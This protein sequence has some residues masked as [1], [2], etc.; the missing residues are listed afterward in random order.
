M[1]LGTLRTAYEA[2]RIEEENQVWPDEQLRLAQERYQ[3][4]A[5]TFLELLEAETVKARADRER[6]AAIYAYHEALA[7]LEVLVGT[8][9]RTP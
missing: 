7:S 5:A 6:I 9:L 2:A 4:G 3:L 1:V 8:T